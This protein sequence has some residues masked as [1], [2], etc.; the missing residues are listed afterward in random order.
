[1]YHKPAAVVRAPVVY[2][3]LPRKVQYRQVVKHIVKPIERKVVLEEK[4]PPLV[5][6]QQSFGNGN[7]PHFQPKYFV[8]AQ[9]DATELCNRQP[10][11]NIV[12]QQNILSQNGMVSESSVNKGEVMDNNQYIQPLDLS[13]IYYKQ[14]FPSSYTRQ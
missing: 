13:Q 14:S 12:Y 3:N 2:R 7:Q 10:T 9:S 1:M 11:T 6:A 4:Q 5:F 8:A